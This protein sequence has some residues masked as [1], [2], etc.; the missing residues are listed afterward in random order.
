VK[1]NTHAYLSPRNGKNLAKTGAVLTV[2]K[3]F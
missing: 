3:T 2:S 1:A